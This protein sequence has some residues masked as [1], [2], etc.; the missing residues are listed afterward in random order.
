MWCELLFAVFA[1]VVE[2]NIP[3]DES[4]HALC[5]EMLHSPGHGGAVILHIAFGRQ[6]HD[7]KGEA[8]AFGLH[9]QKYCRDAMHRRTVRIAVY[10][11]QQ[12]GD[13]VFAR[14]LCP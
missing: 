4:G 3:E 2:E 5:L 7:V 8:D 12:R 13:F 11:R 9:L 14:L 1:Y 10:G 6:I